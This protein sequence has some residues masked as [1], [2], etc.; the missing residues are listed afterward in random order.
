MHNMLKAVLLAAVV[1]P[2]CFAEIGP[3]A[4][5]PLEDS[6]GSPRLEIRNYRFQ[7]HRGQGFERLVLEFSRKDQNPKVQ[8]LV[9]VTPAGAEMDI[10]IDRAV[11]MGAIP[12]SLINDSYQAKSRYLGALSVNADNPAAGFSLRTALKNPKAKLKAFWL[13]NPPRLV[14]D[15]RV[16][17]EIASTDEGGSATLKVTRKKPQPP[18]FERFI[19]FPAAAKVGMNVVFQMAQT[20]KE[21]ELKNVHVNLQGTSVQEEAAPPPD[22]IVCYPREAQV[23]AQLGFEMP[24]AEP[25]EGTDAN[26]EPAPLQTN[27]APRPSAAPT[28]GMTTTAADDSDMTLNPE[29]AGAKATGPRMP[30]SMMAPRLAAPILPPPPSAEAMPASAPETIKKAPAA[31]SPASLLPPLK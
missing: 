27:S 13:A 20:K 31:P 18:A 12:E 8:P 1:S 14:I 19:C 11:L 7:A 21:E 26:T 9:K 6:G 24:K 4:T 17:K 5:V 23:V 15:V 2:L 25:N 22:A 10:A 29:P 28:G 3:Q 30:G 16:G